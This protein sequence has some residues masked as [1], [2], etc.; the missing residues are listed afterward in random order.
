MAELLNAANTAGLCV[1]TCC[2]ERTQ[3]QCTL[4]QATSTTIHLSPLPSSWLAFSRWSLSA[5]AGTGNG[6]SLTPVVS[7]EAQKMLYDATELDYLTHIIIRMYENK[8][9]FVRFQGHVTAPTVSGGA[10]LTRAA[11]QISC[12]WMHTCAYSRQL[13]MLVCAAPCSAYACLTYIVVHDC[14]VPVDSPQRFRL[15]LLFSPGANFSP[16]EVVPLNK[17]HTL[18]VQP[19]A[20]LHKG[21]PFVV[22]LACKLCLLLCSSPSV[23]S[24]DTIVHE[25][26]S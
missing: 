19:R 8:R 20:C 17:D 21:E 25:G 18:P 13:S 5:A 11:L 23:L 24:E 16:Y 15:E 14:R 22:R 26:C 4:Q 10:L 2:C 12:V 9:Y 3:S 1:L 7:E 6:S